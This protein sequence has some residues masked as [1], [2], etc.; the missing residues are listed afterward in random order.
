M[1]DGSRSTVVCAATRWA[2][3]ASPP[4][5]WP[6][7]ARSSGR[8][9]GASSS[10]RYARCRSNAG[11][12]SSRM[13]APIAAANRSRSVPDQPGG[14]AADGRASGHASSGLARRSSSS[15]TTLST[16]ARGATSPSRAEARRPATWRSIHGPISRQRASRASPSSTV[17]SGWKLGMFRNV[18]WGPS[19]GSTDHRATPLVTTPSSNSSVSTSAS[20]VTRSVGV[21]PPAGIC[22]VRSSCSARRRRSRSIAPSSFGGSPSRYRRSPIAVA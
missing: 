15:A 20:R 9:I 7:P 3:A 10:A 12:M 21:M 22:R 16:S 19:S 4:G 2:Y 5:T 17:A 11:R 6:S 1:A 18:T 14:S 13:A 8:A